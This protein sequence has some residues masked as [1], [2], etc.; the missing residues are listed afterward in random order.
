PSASFSSP[1]SSTH[2]LLG[3]QSTYRNDFLSFLRTYNI[4][5]LEGGWKKGSVNL[6]FPSY[7]DNL[8]VSKTQATIDMWAVAVLTYFIPTDVIVH[9]H[10]MLLLEKSLIILGSDA[11]LVSILCTGFLHL[12]APYKWTGIFVPLLP[13]LAQEVLEAPVPFIVGMYTPELFSR[14]ATQRPKALTAQHTAN[15]LYVDD[16]VRYGKLYKPMPTDLQEFRTS[17]TEV[18]HLMEQEE[19]LDAPS[20]RHFEPC[21]DR[22]VNLMVDILC[23]DLAQKLSYQHKRF[24]HRMGQIYSKY[25][26]HSLQHTTSTSHIN[27]LVQDL[28]FDNDDQL[29]RPISKILQFTR[30]FNTEYTA[31][32]LGSSHAWQHVGSLNASSGYLEIEVERVM[33]PMRMKMHFQEQFLC[34]QMFTT[35]A[36]IKHAQY[37]DLARHRYD[38][39]FMCVCT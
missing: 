2:S 13:P 24:M 37:Q 4:N 36:D 9:I 26:L 1:L 10:L 22:Q 34:T 27:Q 20:L 23:K 39:N 19:F 33:Q 6:S 12:L 7:M 21:V 31:G 16:F 32:L 5:K 15:I 28:L 30:D 18:E 29:Y 35:F 17:I 14:E 25:T 3:L 11:A 8:V 38:S